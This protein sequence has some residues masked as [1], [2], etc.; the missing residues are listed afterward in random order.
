MIN[1]IRNAEVALGQWEFQVLGAGIR[2]GDD[3]WMARYIL[4][5][6]AEMKGVSINFA[7]KPQKGDWNGSGCHTNY[8]TLSMREGT[9]ENISNPCSRSKVPADEND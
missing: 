6:I 9:D 2:A 4:Q 7:P 5:R 3:L 8:S 1:N